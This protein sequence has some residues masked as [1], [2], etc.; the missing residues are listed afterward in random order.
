[1]KKRCTMM[2]NNSNMDDKKQACKTYIEQTK[3]L[4]T[5][6]SGF[7]IPPAI[8]LVFIQNVN[9]IFFILS[10]VSLIF[11][12]VMSYLVM[13]CIAGSQDQ[14]TYDVYRPTTRIFSLLQFF[15]YILGLTFFFLMIFD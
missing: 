11:S 6:A 4:A 8:I 2:K 12:V 5:L 1:M 14:G 7:I 3:H 15:S 9:L 13:G 10:E